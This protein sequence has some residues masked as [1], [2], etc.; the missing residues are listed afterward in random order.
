MEIEKKKKQSFDDRFRL[1]KWRYRKHKQKT[2]DRDF[3]KK[4]LDTFLKEGGRIKKST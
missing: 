2:Y 1:D 4:A 3:N